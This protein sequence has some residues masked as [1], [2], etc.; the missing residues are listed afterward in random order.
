MSIQKGDEGQCHSKDDKKQGPHQE[1][2][3]IDDHHEIIKNEEK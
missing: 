2:S 1:G 3:F